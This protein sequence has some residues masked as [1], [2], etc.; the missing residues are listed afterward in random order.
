MHTPILP[1]RLSNPHPAVAVPAP[2][3]AGAPFASPFT[4]DRRL[5]GVS[6]CAGVG[7]IC[8]L[9]DYGLHTDAYWIV[10]KRYRC[11]LAE[12]RARQ[13]ATCAVPAAALLYLSIL[14]QVGPLRQSAAAWGCSWVPH[15]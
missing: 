15:H 11:S 8:Q 9:L 2:Q 10:L 14:D 3:R 1:S 13:R 12:W 7:S 5:L 6:H 4:P